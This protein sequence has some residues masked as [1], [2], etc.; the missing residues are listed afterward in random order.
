MVHAGTTHT[1]GWIIIRNKQ[2]TMTHDVS[3]IKNN[4]IFAYNRL[5]VVF[6]GVFFSRQAI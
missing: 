4:L 1:S 5:L 3:M 2:A 6:I